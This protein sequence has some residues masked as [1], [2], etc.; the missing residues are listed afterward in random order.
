V[1]HVETGEPQQVAILGLEVIHRVHF[2]DGPG[3]AVVARKKLLGH[4]A[5]EAAAHPGD[6]P[7]SLCHFWSFRSDVE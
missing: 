4:V 1:G 5:T 3:D 7:G 6:K 2:A